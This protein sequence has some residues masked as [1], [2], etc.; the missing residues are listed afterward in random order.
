MTYEI[1][2]RVLDHERRLQWNLLENPAQ[3]RIETI[4]ALCAGI[5]RRMP[6]LSRFGAMPDISEKATDLYRDAARKT[7]GMWMR[8]IRLCPICCCTWTTISR[9]PSA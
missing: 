2:R 9:P 1:A 5:T 4:D 6:W 8:K 3:M 7:L